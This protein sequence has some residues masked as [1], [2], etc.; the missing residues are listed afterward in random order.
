MKEP[1][2][3]WSFRV[4][5]T[6]VDFDRIE[7]ELVAAGAT[8]AVVS[9]TDVHGTKHTLAAVRHG[10]LD[11]ALLVHH[12]WWLE[13]VPKVDLDGSRNGFGGDGERLWDWSSVRATIEAVRGLPE[14]RRRAQGIRVTVETV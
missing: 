1:T 11:A 8:A 12:E 4:P 10:S 3:H 6:E 9:W 2:T 13:C 5:A 14:L 7:R